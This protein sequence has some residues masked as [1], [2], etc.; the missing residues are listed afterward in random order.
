MLE[1]LDD[2]YTL[3]S[4]FTSYQKMYTHKIISLIKDLCYADRQAAATSE[5][6]TPDYGAF[7]RHKRTLSPHAGPG[8]MNEGYLRLRCKLIISTSV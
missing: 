4:G 3:G 7:P 6:P 8:I 1:V 5:P 2:C